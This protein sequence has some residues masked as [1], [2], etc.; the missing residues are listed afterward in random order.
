MRF[1]PRRRDRNCRALLRRSRRLPAFA[2]VL[3][4]AA[5]MGAVA[6]A[7]T[8]TPIL[9]FDGADGSEPLPGLLQ[10]RNGSFYGATSAGGAD[11]GGSI[12]RMTPSGTLDTL[13]NFNAEQGHG[14]DAVLVQAADGAFY[15]TTGVG[16][17]RYKGSV[18]KMTPS[19]TVTTIY[20]FCSQPGCVDGELPQAAL[21]QGA[22]GDFYGT[23]TS[24]GAGGEG[25]V[26]RISPGGSLTTLYSF[27]SQDSCADGAQPEGALVQ[28]TDGNFYGTT[29]L[30]G[31]LGDGSVFVLTTSGTLT[32]LYSFC[33]QSRCGDGGYPAAGV[34]QGSDGD[35]YGTTMLGGANNDGT[36]FKITPSG[37]LTTLHSFDYTDGYKPVAGLVQASDGN[38]YGMAPFG[39][40]DSNGTI[41]RTTP[42][43]GF[44][45][46]Y[47]F[48][49]GDCADGYYPVGR[50]AQA[51]SGSFYGVNENG[52]PDAYGDIFVFNAGLA[53]FVKAEP[54]SGLVGSRVQILGTDLVGT[55]SVKFNGVAATFT[56]VSAGEIRTAVPSG[57]TSGTI[58][59]MTPGGTLDSSR[60]F[61]VIP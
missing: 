55:T 42:D 50:L 31:A 17:A 52:G 23:T 29:P 47:E 22:D 26:Y 41:Y 9:R 19:G 54:V 46:L 37:T 20:S 36:V 58:E 48:C 28:G 12:F 49:T 33:S 38:F 18:F 16:G 27:C 59:V 2:V 6:Q 4:S 32:T 14:P 61:A 3:A 34:I 51:L 30:G 10:A 25:S 60:I 11:G 7:Q 1:P 44:T 56:V 45:L 8:L 13:V 24:G 21:V 5:I 40:F 15:G 43:G 57:A 35:F 39:G 53:P